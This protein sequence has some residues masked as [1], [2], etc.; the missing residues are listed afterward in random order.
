M[1]LSESPGFLKR[2]R[3]TPWKFQRTFQTPLQNL[4][5]FVAAIVSAL[6]PSQSA[7][8]VF[9]GI[10][11]PPRHLPTLFAS[12]STPAFTHETTITAC[13][14]ADIAKLLRAALSDWTDF[15]LTT[16]PKSFAIYADHNEYLTVFAH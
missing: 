3:R 9:D 15:V 16:T 14:P 7:T 1:V 2:F 10:I 4:G 13:S 11:F 6:E 12:E 5:P 8:V